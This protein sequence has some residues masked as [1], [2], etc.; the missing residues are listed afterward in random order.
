MATWYPTHARKLPNSDCPPERSDL[1]SLPV[2]LDTVTSV[3]CR[4]PRTLTRQ[5]DP[6]ACASPRAHFTFDPKHLHKP[7]RVQ[8]NSLLPLTAC[9]QCAIRWAAVCPACALSTLES[10]C[11]RAHMTQS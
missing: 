4:W 11:R 10:R 2:V 1:P 8:H 6:P 9:F 5:A 7:R 3:P